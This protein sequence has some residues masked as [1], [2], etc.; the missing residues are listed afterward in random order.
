MASQVSAVVHTCNP[1]YVGGRD[2]EDR[3]LR[4]APAKSYQDPILPHQLG[5][6]VCPCHPSYVGD[7]NRRT[8][9]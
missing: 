8:V 1:S 2:Q 6:V 5:M 3:G 9:V 4:P 7:L